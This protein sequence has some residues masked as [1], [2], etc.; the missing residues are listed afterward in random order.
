LVRAFEEDDRTVSA[1]LASGVAAVLPT[2]T[3][4]MV[5]I[6][7]VTFDGR[8]LS[9]ATGVEASAGSAVAQ[10]SFEA[11]MPAAS[12]LAASFSAQ[13]FLQAADE[14]ERILAVELARGALNFIVL[15]VGDLEA[16]LEFM[17][18]ARTTTL[19][20]SAIDGAGT[21]LLFV[22]SVV[23]GLVFLAI[24]CVGTVAWGAL[25]TCR[26]KSKSC[27]RV[28]AVRSSALESLEDGVGH[29]ASQPLCTSRT[30]PPTERSIAG[31]QCGRMT[32]LGAQSQP[33]PKVQ[34]VRRHLP[35]AGATEQQ[36]SAWRLKL[37]DLSEH[38][39]ALERAATSR[40]DGEPVELHR[41]VSPE[42]PVSRG[43]RGLTSTRLSI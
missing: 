7:G 22:L 14:L 18:F 3:P 4:D 12:T 36:A 26:R 1:A 2:A 23:V 25:K 17:A 21:N 28:P 5:D 19:S 29:R 13:D 34:D 40:R 24:C 31:L 10:I 39:Y 6:V 30:E 41:S 27:D 33:C 16:T 35:L 15:G 42:S 32:N 37:Q 9:E 38:V 20:A 8:L 43:M 11:A